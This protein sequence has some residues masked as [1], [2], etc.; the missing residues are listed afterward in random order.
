MVPERMITFAFALCNSCAETYG[1]PAH[2]YLEPDSLFWERVGMAMLDEKI[3][4]LTELDL[5]AHVDDSSSSIGKLLR[6][7]VALVAKES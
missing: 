6:E 1:D 3:D 7:R 4:G 5:Q 2:F